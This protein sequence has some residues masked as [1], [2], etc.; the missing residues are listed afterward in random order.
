VKEFIEAKLADKPIGDVSVW[1]QNQQ[2]DSDSYV[3]IKKFESE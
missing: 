3:L 1:K 2:I